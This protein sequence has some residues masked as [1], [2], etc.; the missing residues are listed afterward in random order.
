MSGDTMTVALAHTDGTA[1]VEIDPTL[2]PYADQLRGRY[3]HYRAALDRINHLGGLLGQSSLGHTYFGLNRGELY[4]K[5]G[6]WYREWAPH[7]LQVRLIGDFNNWDRFGHP[8]VRD[9][10]GIWSLFL[11]DEKFGT[12]LVHGS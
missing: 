11:P 1:I 9:E 6:V 3:R 10:F 8:L 7:A 2:G 4:G 5:P 12:K